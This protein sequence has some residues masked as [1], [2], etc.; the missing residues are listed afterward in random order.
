MGTIAQFYETGNQSGLK[1]HF[2]NLVMLMRVDGKIDENEKS[3]L[4]TMAQRLSLTDEQVK[5]IQR[6]TT[7]YP[8]QPPASREERY[9]RLLQFAEMVNADGNIDCSE[10]KLMHKYAVALGFTSARIDEICTEIIGRIEKGE[11]A[12]VILDDLMAK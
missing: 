6:D 9:E 3:L 8:M 11:K 4:K 10:L 2:M 5:E 7:Q 12:E 1:G